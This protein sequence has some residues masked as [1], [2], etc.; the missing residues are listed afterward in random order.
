MNIP[1]YQ[2]VGPPLQTSAC[3]FEFCQYCDNHSMV[4][5]L[6]LRNDACLFPV[7]GHEAT[8][9]LRCGHERHPVILSAGQTGPRPT[10]PRGGELPGGAAY[11]W[12]LR[13]ESACSAADPGLIPGSGKFPGERNGYPL[14]Y[15]C[16]ENSMDRGAWWATVH[17]YTSSNVYLPS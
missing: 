8:G 9:S 7:A 5:S 13:Q 12:W 3:G 17:V 11:P 1:K 2:L 16:L 14:Q 6:T 10:R 15:S 4:P